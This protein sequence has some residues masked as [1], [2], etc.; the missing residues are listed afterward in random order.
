MAFALVVENL[1][2]VLGADLAAFGEPPSGSEG[3]GE[4]AVL[5]MERG[6]VLVQSE[7]E[8]ASVNAFVQVEKLRA[9][10]VPRGVERLESVRKQPVKGEAVGR[11]QAVVAGERDATVAED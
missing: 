6:H 5:G 8:T 3:A 10:Q 4:C 7:F 1:D 9:V 2:L 11:V